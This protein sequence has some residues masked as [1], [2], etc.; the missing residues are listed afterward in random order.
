MWEAKYGGRCSACNE[1]IEVGDMLK[2][3]D[4][5]AVH[6]WHSVSDLPYKT[7]TKFQGTTLEDMGF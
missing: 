6:E 1:A 3:V 7:E 2:W 4:G 5:Q